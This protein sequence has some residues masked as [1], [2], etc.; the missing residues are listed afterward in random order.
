MG[1]AWG[2]WVLHSSHLTWSELSEGHLDHEGQELWLNLLVPSLTKN[3]SVIVWLGAL[4]KLWGF[5]R[6]NE[7]S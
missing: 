2:E 1:A 5:M 3:L 6:K 7:V 4:Q